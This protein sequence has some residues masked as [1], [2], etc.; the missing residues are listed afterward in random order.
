MITTCKVKQLYYIEDTK[1]TKKNVVQPNEYSIVSINDSLYK[2]SNNDIKELTLSEINDLESVIIVNALQ[3]KIIHKNTCLL[4]HLT[5][6]AE[7][8]LNEIRCEVTSKSDIIKIN[9]NIMSFYKSL[10]GKQ[11][12]TSGF[13]KKCD[14]CM[15]REVS[16][17][18]NR[19]EIIYKLKMMDINFYNETFEIEQV[20]GLG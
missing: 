15:L 1:N 10:I 8:M 4:F 14:K 17:L 19:N 20:L 16:C 13:H 9:D 2:I 7:Y 11:V 6:I 3:N 12:I 18:I 5:K